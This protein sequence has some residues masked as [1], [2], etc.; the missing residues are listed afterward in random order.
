MDLLSVDDLQSFVVQKIDPSFIKFFRM[1]NTFNATDVTLATVNYWP[2]TGQA[3]DYFQ[4]RLKFQIKHALF[5]TKIQ[6][7]SKSAGKATET[8]LLV[9]SRSSLDKNIIYKYC[10][11]FVQTRFWTGTMR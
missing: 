1:S 4:S 11:S 7:G 6:E 8:V 2:D 5:R 3:K 9:A 10:L